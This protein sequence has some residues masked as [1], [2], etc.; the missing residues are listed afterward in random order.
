MNIAITITIL[1]V[2]AAITIAYIGCAYS[3][4]L[5]RAESY[6]DGFADGYHDGHRDGSNGVSV[7]PDDRWAIAEGEEEAV[8]ADGGESTMGNSQ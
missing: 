3:Y 7:D 8:A 5:G 2:T 4:N 6:D 1:A